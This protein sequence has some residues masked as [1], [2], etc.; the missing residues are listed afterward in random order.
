MS[1][2]SI[3]EFKERLDVLC[4]RGGGRSWPRKPRDQHILLKS[5]T[6][7]LERERTYTEQAVNVQLIEWSNLVGRTIELD[8][9][10]LRRFLMDAGYLRRDRADRTY[11][12]DATAKAELF[13]V[14]IETINPVA[15]VEEAHRRA[16][17]WK[18]AYLRKRREKETGI[19]QTEVNTR[20]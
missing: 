4:M 2:I 5:I 8:Y 18:R 11:R 17:E 3:A 12:V 10:T 20:E 9:V 6:L 16:E 1:K 13:E 7:L 14:E 19:E 15:V